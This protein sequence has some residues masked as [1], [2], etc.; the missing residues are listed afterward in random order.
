MNPRSLLYLRKKK[1]T[2]EEEPLCSSSS[3]TPEKKNKMTMSQEARHHLLHLRKKPRNLFSLC[4]FQLLTLCAQNMFERRKRAERLIVISCNPRKTNIK[5]FFRRLQKTTTSRK[6]HCPLMGFYVFFL[7][8][9][10]MT[11][12]GEA[13]HCLLQCKKK[14][15]KTRTRCVCCCLLPWFHMKSKRRQ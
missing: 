15:K 5:F 1:Q 14:R 13:C 2:N 7:E 6:A 9:Q 10:K 12:S 3:S 4:I 8:L 11:T